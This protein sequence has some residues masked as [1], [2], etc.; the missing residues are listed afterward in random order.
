M[1]PSIAS[2]AQRPQVPEMMT[3]TMDV[4]TQAP[5]MFGRFKAPVMQQHTTEIPTGH[6]VTGGPQ[7]MDV[8][9]NP[10]NPMAGIGGMGQMMP[11][12][13]AAVE[14]MPR[15]S[16]FKSL[17]YPPKQSFAGQGY[18]VSDA[19]EFVRPK[20]PY[21]GERLRQNFEEKLKLPVGESRYAG[22]NLA[23]PIPLQ[24]GAADQFTQY[25]YVP[26]ANF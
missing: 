14:R 23:N 25:E 20:N 4:P 19:G 6:T 8:Q 21:E 24:Q 15:P 5:G 2:M 1:P 26:K 10:E 11:P 12:P 9:Q 3:Q 22:D 7:T 16:P 18:T 13:G 17:D